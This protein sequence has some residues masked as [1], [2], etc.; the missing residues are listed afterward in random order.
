MKLT[1]TCSNCKG[2]TK[3]STETSGEKY[4]DTHVK[5]D[6]KLYMRDDEWGGCGCVAEV[7]GATITVQPKIM[8]NSQCS[9]GK[10]AILQAITSDLESHLSQKTIE[11]EESPFAQL[12]F[13][14]D[15]DGN[16]NLD[17]TDDGNDIIGNFVNDLLYHIFDTICKSRQS[18]DFQPYIISRDTSTVD[19][20]Q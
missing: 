5:I 10:A 1:L 17:Y 18:R 14:D 19:P 3:T 6:A 13:P 4:N 16:D 9:Q 11:A 15:G 20:L 7:C 12:G 8:L 2:E